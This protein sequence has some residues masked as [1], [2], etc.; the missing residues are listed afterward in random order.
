MNVIVSDSSILIEFSKHNIL[1]KMFDLELKFAVPDL[2]FHEELI[3]LGSYCRQDL[4][5]F[6]L[7]V[8]SLDAKGVQVALAYQSER[9]ALS[10]VD[11]FAL[12]LAGSQ[13]WHLLTEDRTMRVFGES[14]GIAH[15]DS[16]WVVDR[17][18]Q[19]GI[20]SANQVVA[21]L[22]AMQDD[23]RCPVPKPELAVRIRL[24]CV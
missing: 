23:P 21:V 17:M 22:K 24:L 14:K 6:G 1:H 7:R 12:T 16:L 2:L 18:L 5:G 10:L 19:V 13:G 20:L 9:P 8:E 15:V 4:L 11:S 3:D